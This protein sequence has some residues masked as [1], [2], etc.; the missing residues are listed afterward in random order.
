MFGRLLFAQ[1][2]RQYEVPTFLMG[3][4]FGPLKLSELQ[5]QSAVVLHSVFYDACRLQVS[6]PFLQNIQRC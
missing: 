5:Q 1:C 3:A 2:F 6:L 4:C